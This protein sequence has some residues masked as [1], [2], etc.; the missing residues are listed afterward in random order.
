MDFSRKVTWE[1]DTSFIHYKLLVTLFFISCQRRANAMMSSLSL[2]AWEEQLNAAEDGRNKES[3]L[4][5]S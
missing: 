1:K 4:N 2:N 5:S 3:L